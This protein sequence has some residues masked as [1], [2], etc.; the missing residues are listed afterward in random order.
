MIG[1]RR[2][3]RYPRVN[4]EPLKEPLPDY[5]DIKGLSKYIDERGKILS[6]SRSGLNAK[7]QRKV[8]REIKRARYLALLPFTQIIK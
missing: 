6:R 3:N 2:F 1:K 8:A 4:K 5:K 7:Q